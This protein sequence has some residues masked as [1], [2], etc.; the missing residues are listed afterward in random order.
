MVETKGELSKRVQTDNSPLEGVGLFAL[1]DIPEDFL[2]H[3]THVYDEKWG[4]VN[5][6]PNYKFNHSRKQE[7]C[8]LVKTESHMYLV[9]LR[10]ISKGEELLANYEKGVVSEIEKPQDNWEK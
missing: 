10:K 4:W 7:N 5:I 6:S 3:E 1:E 2:I 9:S 8:K